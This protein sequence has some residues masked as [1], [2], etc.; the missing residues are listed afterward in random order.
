MRRAS[1]GV[2]GFVHHRSLQ[3]R[4]CPF[5]PTRPF[6]A[7]RA[8][9]SYLAAHMGRGGQ[10]AF[11]QPLIPCLRRLSTLEK[12]GTPVNARPRFSSTGLI[13]EPNER[14]IGLRL[15]EAVQL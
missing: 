13:I 15:E 4:R 10:C 3:V 8:A 1:R 5:C 14:D 7:A 11:S 6:C 12:L 2:L 9:H